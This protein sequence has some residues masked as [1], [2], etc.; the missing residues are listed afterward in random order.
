MKIWDFTT[1]GLFLFDSKAKKKAHID[2][3][4]QVNLNLKNKAI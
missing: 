4:F 3:I 2:L 1:L